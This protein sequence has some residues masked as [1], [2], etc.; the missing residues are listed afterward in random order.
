[1]REAP[2]PGGTGGPSSGSE[3][4]HSLTDGYRQNSGAQ[5]S[6]R[7]N[8]LAPDDRRQQFSSTGAQI[9]GEIN[10][11]L[12]TCYTASIILGLKVS[13]LWSPK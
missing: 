12:D 9:D 1:M 10:W 4:E 8:R 6:G 7:W 2:R 13:S 5:I 3:S 11:K